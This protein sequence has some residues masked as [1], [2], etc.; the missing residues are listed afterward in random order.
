LKKVEK[1]QEVECADS[2]TVTVTT[3][4]KS[5]EVEYAENSTVTKPEITDTVSP[6][7]HHGEIYQTGIGASDARDLLRH[8]KRPWKHPSVGSGFG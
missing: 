6:S 8:V 7:V 2:S 4:E 5:Q 3:I 1:S